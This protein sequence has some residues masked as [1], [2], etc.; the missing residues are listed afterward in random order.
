[1]TVSHLQA[2][3]NQHSRRIDATTT[4][5]EVALQRLIADAT[6]NLVGGL[7]SRLDISADGEI[8]ATAKNAR[9][10]RNLQ[11][12]LYKELDRAGL[13][14]VVDSFVAK[15]P[16]Q[17]PEF[18]DILRAVAAEDGVKAPVINWTKADRANWSGF[19]A[20]ALSGLDSEIQ[21]GLAGIATRTLFAYGGLRFAEL[22]K[23]VKARFDASVSRATQIA[24]DSQMAFYRSISD[25]SFSRIEENL[26]SVTMHYK[27]VGPD[28]E[29]TSVICE[30]W[31]RH[32]PFT[33]AEIDMLKPIYWPV[34]TAFRLGG[35]PNCRHQFLLNLEPLAV[36]NA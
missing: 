10:L 27:Y 19:Q 25:V 16:G 34:G 29:V 21:A 15:L 17:V 23:L 18:E 11:A 7:H 32:K 22:V 13:Q 4:E 33:R 28:D 20:N 12:L 36:A 30:V 6:A 1:M 3:L 2:L 8:L 35:H 24:H 5:F 9:V 14:R 31:M 26:P